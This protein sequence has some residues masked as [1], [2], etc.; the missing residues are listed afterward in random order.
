MTNTLN[1]PQV[2]A[3]L[4]R[5]F[6]GAA[7]DDENG[8]GLAPGA[9]STASASELAD[10]CQRI[11]MPVS[12]PGGRLLY[13]L[14]RAARPDTV[15]EFGTSF[16][17]SAAHL[18]AAVADNGTGRVLTTELSPAKIAAATANLEDA[19][20]ADVVSVLPGDALETLAAV[21]G[22]VGLV[23]LDG[24][25]DLC[26][27]VLRLLEPE[28]APG[29]LVV[30]DDVDSHASMAGYLAYV[31]DPANGYVTIGFPVEDGMEVS[32]WTGA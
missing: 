29:A 2:R 17:I 11:Y 18:A 20:L 27:P 23:F 7:L 28:L 8:P 26:L 24:W 12:E 14:T 19:G 10:A 25:K 3:V 5:L 1:S 32:C 31:R 16:G 22:P 6:E 30:A 15:V 9:W 13:A 21:Q 4:D